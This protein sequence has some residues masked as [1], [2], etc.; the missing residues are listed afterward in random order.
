MKKPL[1]IIMVLTMSINLHAQQF[2]GVSFGMP[3]DKCKI[4]LDRRFNDWEDSYQPGKDVL[5]YTKISFA[6]ESFDYVFFWFTQT[7]T[8]RYLN[9]AMFV[10][11]VPLGKDQNDTEKRRE[12]SRSM[13]KRLVRTYL[14]KKKDYDLVKLNEDSYVISKGDSDSEIRFGV[15][16]TKDEFSVS[17]TY[18]PVKIAGEDDDI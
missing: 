16:E 15:E 3:Y 4:I 7:K 10:S 9:G 13:L 8:G 1:I 14:A 12:D 5:I 6:G 11:E 2:A 18:G 17:V